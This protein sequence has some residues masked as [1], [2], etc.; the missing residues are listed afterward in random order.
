RRSPLLPML[1]VG[2]MIAVW[3]GFVAGDATVAEL[4]DFFTG[5]AHSIRD[6]IL[7]KSESKKPFSGTGETTNSL[8]RA[9]MLGA[10]LLS[11]VLMSGGLIAIWKR[12]ARGPLLLTL[13]LVGA[14][15]PVSLALRLT[16]ASTEI[17]GR[18]PEF[19]FIGIAALAAFLASQ[20]P[21]EGR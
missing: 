21:L 11:L 15:L 20:I 3:L 13:A 12:R 1:V 19:V 2:V 17:S 9:L 18:A 5:A 8:E 4:G 14:F 16:Q 7:N 6:L 10:V